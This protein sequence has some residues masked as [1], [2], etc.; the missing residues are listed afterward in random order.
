MKRFSITIYLIIIMCV[1]I[2]PPYLRLSKGEKS[3]LIELESQVSGLGARVNKGSL[4]RIY[5]HNDQQ[6]RFDGVQ[7]IAQDGRR[8][9][10]IGF[11]KFGMKAGKGFVVGMGKSPVMSLEGA[12]NLVANFKDKE[13]SF[14]ATRNGE[15]IGTAKGRFSGWT[16]IILSEFGKLGIEE[17]LNYLMKAS[18]EE[19]LP[20]LIEKLEIL[21][22]DSKKA[23]STFTH[24][25]LKVEK[26]KDKYCLF[27]EGEGEIVFTPVDRKISQTSDELHKKGFLRFKIQG[28]TI[29]IFYFV[30][31]GT[32][33]NN[34]RKTAEAKQIGKD[35]KYISDREKVPEVSDKLRLEANKTKNVEAVVSQESIHEAARKGD[36][37]TI[38]KLVEQGV[39]INETDKD[40][41]TPLHVAAAK[42]YMEIVRYLTEYKANPKT[43]DKPAY[44]QVKP[45]EETTVPVQVEKNTKENISPQRA[46]EL[47]D[48]IIAISTKVKSPQPCRL[49]NR[50]QKLIDDAGLNFVIAISNSGC[51]I[52][53]ADERGSRWNIGFNK[54]W[55]CPISLP[56]KEIPKVEFRNGEFGIIAGE[57]YV[58]NGTEARIQGSYYI[59]KEDKWQDM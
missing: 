26:E 31:D 36:L 56:D 40:G 32:I 42:G 44:V 35:E 47:I 7:G 11:E 6:V 3:M 37:A 10:T 19:A 14:L 50:L 29:P 52:R 58:E 39:D 48:I 51:P 54:E 57:P 1:C 21:A 38:K 23:I 8:E 22:P 49:S 34:Q 45:K 12:G 4:D 17:T 2:L 24:K 20:L 55:V 41:N 59:F 16:S 5:W 13:V 28:E 27:I 46:R 25:N 15:T 53:P 43:Q 9:V 30:C 18:G 33:S